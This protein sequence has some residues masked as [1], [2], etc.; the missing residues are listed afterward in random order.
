MFFLKM[1]SGIHDLLIGFLI[2]CK[3]KKKPHMSEV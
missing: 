1:V 3:A 2:D